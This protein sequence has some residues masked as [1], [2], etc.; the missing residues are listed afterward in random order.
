MKKYFILFIYILFIYKRIFAYHEKYHNEGYQVS[1][2]LI[3]YYGIRKSESDAIQEN[4]F[5][6]I[7]NC[8]C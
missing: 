6:D 8:N 1:I 3:S 7:I 5:S 4:A 2:D